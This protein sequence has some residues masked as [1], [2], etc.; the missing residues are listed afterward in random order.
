MSNSNSHERIVADILIAALSAK[1]LE[2]KLKNNIK[3]N[4]QEIAEAFKIIH[5]AVSDLRYEPGKA[6]GQSYKTEDAISPAENTS[7]IGY[8]YRFVTP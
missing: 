7:K 6:E 5:R 8:G 4:A 3:S 2:P 1:F